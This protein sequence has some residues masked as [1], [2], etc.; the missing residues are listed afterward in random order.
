MQA[1]IEQYRAEHV[2][3][4]AADD[5][6]LTMLLLAAV[7]TELGEYAQAEPLLCDIERLASVRPSPHPAIA[8]ARRW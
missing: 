1:R 7:H 2:T 8:K 5:Q 3:S 6:A 4:M